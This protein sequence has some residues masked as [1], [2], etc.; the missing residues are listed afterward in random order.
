VLEEWGKINIKIGYYTHDIQIASALLAVK[1][2]RE[3]LNMVDK[4]TIML[5]LTRIGE[6]SKQHFWRTSPKVE[7][8]AIF[9]RLGIHASEFVEFENAL[10]W[11][12]IALSKGKL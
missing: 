9:G 12:Q 7:T 5:L 8:R 6:W 11:A 3:A 2:D 1:E 10:G 4:G